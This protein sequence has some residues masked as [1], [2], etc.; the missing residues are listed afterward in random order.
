MIEITQKTKK[1]TTDIEAQMLFSRIINCQIETT[2][3]TKITG[4]K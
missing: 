4:T 1:E 3:K 2:A